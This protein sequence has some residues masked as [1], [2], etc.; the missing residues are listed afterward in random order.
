MFIE[1]FLL[2]Y[3]IYG[4]EGVI[5]SRGQRIVALQI[6]EHLNCSLMEIILTSTLDDLKKDPT[7]N[8]NKV[9]CHLHVDAFVSFPA[10][11]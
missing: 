7:F 2:S 1:G 5:L 11:A 10:S 8:P 4:I 6:P 3:T 9:E